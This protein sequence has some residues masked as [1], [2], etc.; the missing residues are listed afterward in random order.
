MSIDIQI[1]EGRVVVMLVWWVRFHY[2]PLLLGLG[3]FFGLEVF[4]SEYD[5]VE[6][7]MW[8]SDLPMPSLSVLGK[9]R[10]MMTYG[11]G[12]VV[13]YL[14]ILKFLILCGFVKVTRP[15]INWFLRF[16]INF[17]FILFFLCVS[18][19]VALETPV[20]LLWIH[21]SVWSLSPLVFAFRYPVTVVIFLSSLILSICQICLLFETDRVLKQQL[22]NQQQKQQ[23]PQQQQQQPQ[24]QLPQQQPEQQQQ[25]QQQQ[26][27]KKE[28]KK[29]NKEKQQQQQQQQQKQKQKQQQIQKP[30]QHLQ[31]QQPQQRIGKRK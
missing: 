23:Q 4:I 19:L 26:Q 17:H 7:Y 10:K 5:D 30:K 1:L 16:L 9:V 24:Q 15:K 22:K 20:V 18:F 11:L 28:K 6:E 21:R 14:V 27:Q 31:Q 29:K 25:Q 3:V 2:L 12:V 13:L 8:P